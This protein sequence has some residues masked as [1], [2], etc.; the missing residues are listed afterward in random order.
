MGTNNNYSVY[1][2]IDDYYLGSAIYRQLVKKGANCSF[3]H[4]ALP[5]LNDIDVDS[6]FISIFN[7]SVFNDTDFLRF[8]ADLSSQ[9][10]RKIIILENDTE[11]ELPETWGEVRCIDASKELSIQMIETI[12]GVA[13][14]PLGKIVNPK[15]IADEKRRAENERLEKERRAVEEVARKKEKAERRVCIRSLWPHTEMDVVLDDVEVSEAVQ[16]GVKYLTGQGLPLDGTR[17]FAIFKKLHE[18][19][20][21]DE[22]ISYYYGLCHTG[23]YSNLNQEDAYETSLK[24]YKKGAESGLETTLKAYGVMLLRGEKYDIAA[25]V[26]KKL[27]DI[28]YPLGTYYLGYVD[29]MTDN[30]SEAIEKYYEAAEEGVAEAQNALGCMYTEAWG[31]EKDW[32]KALQ[33]FELAASQGLV[34]AKI[35]IGLLYLS[36]GIGETVNQGIELIKQIARETND[37]DAIAIDEENERKIAELMEQENRRLKKQQQKEMALK[38]LGSA[39]SGTGA[40]LKDAWNTLSD[41]KNL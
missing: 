27:R 9:A 14:E 6:T 8:I 16:K 4:G 15:Q 10:D 2:A 13:S 41:S 32:D 28:N 19:K 33:W 5:N 22:I 25:E 1:C 38:I 31:V 21:E 24:A 37:A 39:L 18:E 26:F 29:E 23:G 36:S 20:P 3:Y 34:K 35:N 7:E 11:A 30:Y 17:A 40:Q 12:M